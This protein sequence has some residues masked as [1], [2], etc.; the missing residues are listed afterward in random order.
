MG[1]GLGPGK[2]VKDDDVEPRLGGK[3]RQCVARVADMGGQPCTVGHRQFLEDKVQEFTFQFNGVLFGAR[4]GGLDV[5]GQCKCSGAQM[6]GP[7]GAARFCGQVHHVP[8]PAEVFIEDLT[9]RRQVH[10]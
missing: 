9:G 6:K 4:S 3:L 1:R 2:D 7:D 10:V 5:A 8:D